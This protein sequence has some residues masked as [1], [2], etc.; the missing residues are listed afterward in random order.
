MFEKILE[1]LLDLPSKHAPGT[2]AKIVAHLLMPGFVMAL[3]I[4]SVYSSSMALDLSG[5][6]T[7]AELQTQVDTQGRITLKPGI[8][9]TVE[10]VTSEY[11]IPL[12]AG[13]TIWTSL[14]SKTAK[15]NDDQLVVTPTEV[16]ARSPFWGVS[17][18]VTVV[19]AG[20]ASGEIWLR[21]GKEPL[22]NW[23][24]EPRRSLAF[25]S[26]ILLVCVFVFGMSLTAVLPSHNSVEDVA[27]E[28]RANPN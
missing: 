19:V 17:A 25:L 3:A 21:G 9:L 24:L 6:V 12:N 18:P 16:R 13:S 10:P 2:L 4:S 8:A 1:I 23:R 15:V 14:D 20:Q 28:A 22:K 11:R 26:N 27:A 5:P 7:V